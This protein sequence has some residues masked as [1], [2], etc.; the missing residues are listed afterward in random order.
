[1]KGTNS[2]K[3]ARGFVAFAGI[4]LLSLPSCRPNSIEHYVALDQTNRIDF[5]AP[6]W[7]EDYL[8]FVSNQLDGIAR[9]FQGDAI[10]CPLFHFVADQIENYREGG[11]ALDAVKDIVERANYA[12][13]SRIFLA[14]LV[15]QAQV[16]LR[17]N[18][19][20]N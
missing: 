15:L 10:Y 4:S 14:S 7:E 6:F 5:Q 13:L 17:S 1:M 11:G 19:S 3:S 12:G 9:L 2:R 16:R 18:W 20:A 8:S